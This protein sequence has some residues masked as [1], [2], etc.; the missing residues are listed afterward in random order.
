MTIIF[1]LEFNNKIYY[2]SSLEWI[3][4][5]YIKNSHISYIK[6]PNTIEIASINALEY[7]LKSI[8]EKAE[9][10]Q[11]VFDNSLFG[12][13]EIDRDYNILQKNYVRYIITKE[14]NV[15]Y[16]LYN[17]DLKIDKLIQMRNI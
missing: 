4:T 14:E 15:D 1:F 17:R 13:V 11:C 12:Y 10:Q 3:K 6:E 8:E 5:I 16:K 2:R 7:L 9:K